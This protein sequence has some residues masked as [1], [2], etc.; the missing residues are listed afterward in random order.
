MSKGAP[1]VAE[2]FPNSCGVEVRIG[3]AGEE[4]ERIGICLTRA[5]V[6]AR[7]LENNAKVEQASR[8]LG[9]TGPFDRAF[10]RTRG[11]VQRPP[12]MVQGRGLEPCS[13]VLCMHAQMAIQDCLGL[14]NI[15]ASTG[16][17]QRPAPTSTTENRAKRAG[18]L[19]E[20]QQRLSRIGVERT[21][22][23]SHGNAPA[24][25]ANMNCRGV[26]MARERSC[27]TGHGHTRK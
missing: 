23:I 24:T 16:S 17:I 10:V 14:G 21:S 15:P 12:K 2:P 25:G 26:G 7:V 22:G 6:S 13:G 20:R 11:G 19:I 8:P 27:D 9:S 1:A 5:V 18:R 4:R 3:K